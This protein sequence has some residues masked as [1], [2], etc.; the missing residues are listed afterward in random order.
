MNMQYV[1]YL[2]FTNL[3]FC[4]RYFFFTFFL[5]KKKGTTFNTSNNNIIGVK[6]LQKNKI[7]AKTQDF[8]FTF[9]ISYDK[10]N[11]KKK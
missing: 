11:S 1:Q 6:N 9:S 8:I 3:F 4:L 5:P 7:Q 10:V 2:S